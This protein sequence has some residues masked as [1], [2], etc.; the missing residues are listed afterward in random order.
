MARREPVGAKP[1]AVSMTF[2]AGWVA[3]ACGLLNLIGRKGTAGHRAGGLLFVLSMCLVAVAGAS[4][5]ATGT[6]DLFALAALA[7][8]AA[9]I[10][11]VLPFIRRSPGWIEQ[12]ATRMQVAFVALSAAA[13][14]EIVAAEIAPRMPGVPLW[15]GEAAMTLLV[16]LI[17][18]RLALRQRAEIRD[19]AEAHRLA[20]QVR[21]PR[22]R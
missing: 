1:Y 18:W 15:E 21:T 9:T 6:I 3:L 2:L 14:D 19:A 13:G 4:R 8:F 20:P 12:H 11:A 5:A 22:R 10:W 7:S 17:G 16:V